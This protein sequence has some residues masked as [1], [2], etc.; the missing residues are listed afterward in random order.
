MG[1]VTVPYAVG[2]FGKL[3]FED[4][5][6]MENPPYAFTNVPLRRS[7]SACWISSGVFITK[8]P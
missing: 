5:R 7:S 6:L 3:R 8:G 4:H 2:E 1:V